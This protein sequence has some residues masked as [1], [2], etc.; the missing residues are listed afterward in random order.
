MPHSTATQPRSLRHNG[1]AAT[2]LGSLQGMP[3]A[4]AFVWV[5]LVALGVAGR[6]WQPAWN[7]TPMAAVALAAGAVFPS[8]VVA[9]SVPLAALVVSNL[10]LDAYD[11]L[12]MAAV[13]LIAT[14]WPVLLGGLLRR[15]ASGSRTA[16]VIAPLAGALASSLVFFL[17]TNLAFW[18]CTA[19]YPHTAEGLLACFTAALP[20]YRWMPAGDLA[21]TAATF[22]GLAAFARGIDS[23]ASRRLQ[24]L[25]AAAQSSP[26]K[27]ASD[28]A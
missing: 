6:L 16:A 20:F 2:L 24:P 1:D 13:V 10:G 14:A 18:W 19:E 11:S 17:T 21:W 9:A 7:V 4:L 26:A 23:V 25:A 15:M 28:V 27:R 3:A 12:P 8:V 22:A 5:A